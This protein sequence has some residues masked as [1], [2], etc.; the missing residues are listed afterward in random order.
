[1]SQ[2]RFAGSA[3][4]GASRAFRWGTAH[5]DWGLLGWLAVTLSAFTIAELVS[6]RDLPTA[7]AAAVAAVGLRVLALL[8]TLAAVLGAARKIDQRIFQLP[9]IGHG[10][11]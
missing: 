9:G 8:A 10:V 4:P 1:M 2:S 5:H 7:R 3:I 11:P 6:S